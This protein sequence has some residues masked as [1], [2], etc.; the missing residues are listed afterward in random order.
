PGRAPETPPANDD[1]TNPMNPLRRVDLGLAPPPSGRAPFFY[2]W[3]YAGAG[4]QAFAYQKECSTEEPLE[5]GEFLNLKTLWLR[6]P[7]SDSGFRHDWTLSFETKIAEAFDMP[8]RLLD[9][10][11]RSLEKMRQM[12][13]AS[14]APAPSEIEKL[15]I[16]EQFHNAFIASLRD[17]ANYGLSIPPD[18]NNFPQSTNQVLKFKDSL[19]Q[20][21]LA[22]ERLALTPTQQRMLL[23]R[24][25]EEDSRITIADWKS[26]ISEITGRVENSPDESPVFLEPPPQDA[27]N[28]LEKATEYLSALERVYAALADERILLEIF[29]ENWKT[30]FESFD[31]GANVWTAKSADI[32]IILS[33][34][35]LRK[36]LLLGNAGIGWRSLRGRLDNSTE[37]KRLLKN[38]LLNYY[39]NRFEPATTVD[40]PYRNYS[41]RAAKIPDVTPDL[42]FGS[43]SD[44]FEDQITIGLSGFAERIVTENI[45]PQANPADEAGGAIVETLTLQ[46]DKM[47]RDGAGK[48]VEDQN[49]LVRRL[50]GIGVLLRR[51]EGAANLRDWSCLNLAQLKIKN[52]VVAE[53]AA[54]PIPVKLQYRNGVRQV[55][56]SYDNQPLAAQSPAAALSKARAMRPGDDFL[57]DADNGEA[58]EEIETSQLLS[59]LNPYGLNAGAPKLEGLIY[60][61]DYDATVFL[62]GS[63]GNLPKELAQTVDTGSANERK[64]PY[65]F[66]RPAKDAT[67]NG[68]T[69]YSLE[70]RRLVKVGSI[71]F[72]KE[73]AATTAGAVAQETQELNL[74][75]IPAGVYPL[76]RSKFSA[77]N[78][79]LVLLVPPNRS[80]WNDLGRTNFKFSVRPPSIDLKVWDRWIADGGSTEMMRERET[81]WAE[82]HER[83]DTDETDDKKLK[84]DATIDDPSIVAFTF[85]LERK[86]SSTSTTTPNP[87]EVEVQRNPSAQGLKLMQSDAIDVEIESKET[88]QATLIKEGRKTVKIAIPAGEIWQLKI[89]PKFSAVAERKFNPSVWQ[90]V[91]LPEVKNTVLYIEVAKAFFDETTVKTYSQNLY[92]AVQVRH[93]TLG[94]RIQISLAPVAAVKDLIYGVDL[95]MQ[96]WRWDGR[97]LCYFDKPAAVGESTQTIYGFP[98]D[99]VNED[100]SVPDDF[101]EY[102]GIFFGSRESSDHKSVPKQKDFA[103]VNVEL[104]APFSPPLYDEELTGSAGALYFRVA[105]RVTSRYA[106]LMRRDTTLDSRLPAENGQPENWKRLVIRARYNKIVPRPAIKMIVPLS[107]TLAEKE[108]PGLLVI[109]DEAA[110]VDSIGGLA[111]RFKCDVVRVARPDFPNETRSEFAPDPILDMSEDPYR[112]SRIEMPPVVGA[113]GYTFDTDTLAPL[114]HKAS[115][116]Q[117]PPSVKV[118]SDDEEGTM[119]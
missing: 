72:G 52:T 16:P 74:P 67:F 62:I 100:G 14:P 105:A 75:P 119:R 48:D 82:Y 28:Y 73:S 3:N 95:L 1:V 56:V 44:S 19:A 87:I 76:T 43:E 90:K 4:L 24:L 27:V 34:L 35:Q 80:L 70:F 46:V 38:A 6:K 20:F 39:E 86:N 106:G 97:P 5:A 113:I 79:P 33:N 17:V 103:S 32:R 49:D 92:N 98:F 108:T 58:Q 88:G 7:A 115:F 85:S 25:S 78:K 111:E 93:E 36:R 68:A 64:I 31:L 117:P 23:G 65:L 22:H 59:F 77:D 53:P 26:V 112:E 107:Q 61:K 12:M 118:S 69:I 84:G 89:E 30:V 81:I 102:D 94:D 91:N 54:V 51:D 8:A 2:E 13:S 45:L 99:K 110:Y 10:L 60:G 83:N 109:L 71:R 40:S 9:G 101:A 41:P 15:K 37:L 66:A 47:E 63:A 96:R 116:I 57:Q 114:F 21:V 42:A 55:F 11:R 50:A 104:P 29:V 18:G